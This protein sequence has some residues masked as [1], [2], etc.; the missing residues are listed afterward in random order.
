MSRTR[1]PIGTLA[2]RAFVAP[3]GAQSTTSPNVESSGLPGQYAYAVEPSLSADGRKVAFASNAAVRDMESIFPMQIF[4]TRHSNS[5]PS[6][7]PAA[8]PRRRR[9]LPGCRSTAP[10]RR[11]PCHA[12]QPGLEAGPRWDEA[13]VRRRAEVLVDLVL[14]VRALRD[15]IDDRLAE[16]RIEV[17]ETVHDRVRRVVVGGGGGDGLHERRRRDSRT[18]DAEEAQDHDR[19]LAVP[20]LGGAQARAEVLER[21]A[22]R[23]R[24]LA[25]ANERGQRSTLVVADRR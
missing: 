5:M 4:R 14:A 23:G 12:R 24:V 7:A 22:L 2:A 21:L 10:P 15:E 1:F 3:A 6:T 19:A 16:Q 11:S 25:D 9:R 17:P 18:T 20:Q 8:V 13:V